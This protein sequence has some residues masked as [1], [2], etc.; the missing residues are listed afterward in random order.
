[1]QFKNNTKQRNTSIQGLRSFK[2]TLPKNLKKIISKKGHI[3]SE[4]LSNW[5]YL[6]GNEL[7][8]V[9]FPKTFKN[10]NRFGVSTLVVMVK[11]GHEV[12][13]EYSKKNILDKMNNFFGYDVV[14]K[15]KFISFDDKQKTSS[16]NEINSNNVAISK[17]R[18]KIKDVK[19]EKIKKS[20]TELT[21]VYKEK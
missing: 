10:S 13:V 17:Y 4:T 3:Y 9:C 7:F 2:D 18:D 15:L 1:M 8:K 14:E 21:K 11:R 20:L 19:N 5:K 16:L 12:D 6:V